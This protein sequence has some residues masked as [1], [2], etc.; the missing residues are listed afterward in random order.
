M[1]YI[2]SLVGPLASKYAILPI[3]IPLSVQIGV[4]SSFNV[5]RKKSGDEDVSLL[6][7]DSRDMFEI[8]LPLV[9]EAISEDIR[10][11][12][13]CCDFALIVG[14]FAKSD[15]FC[16]SISLS[17]LFLKRAS[18]LGLGIEISLYV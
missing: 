4:V 8:A 13:H 10:S 18:E 5:Q 17:P 6:E 3:K 12:T 16:R 7:S 2:L 15:E 11:D 9:L 14:I 1:N